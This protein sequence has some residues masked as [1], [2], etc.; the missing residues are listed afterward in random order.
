MLGKLGR[1]RDQGGRKGQKPRAKSHRTARVMR[2]R[3][4]LG[5]GKGK[6]GCGQEEWGCARERVGTFSVYFVRIQVHQLSSL[7]PTHIN[8]YPP[9]TSLVAKC[10]EWLERKSHSHTR[11]TVT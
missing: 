3:I 5:G 1:A 11:R 10:S 8:R 9:H 2:R 6:G 4:K 7:S